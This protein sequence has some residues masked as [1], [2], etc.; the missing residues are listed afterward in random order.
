MHKYLWK[1]IALA[2]LTLFIIL[3]FSYTLIV[4]FI[5]NPFEIKLQDPSLSKELR[6]VYRIKAREYDATPVIVK[7]VNYFKGFFQGNFGDIMF[8]ANGTDARTIPELFFKPLKYSLL[9]SLPAFVISAVL[10]ITLGVFAGYKRGTLWDSIINIFVFVFIAIPSFI[11]APFFIDLFAKAGFRETFVAVG[12]ETGHGPATP[13]DSFVSV[14]PAILV[15]TL[16]S[17][18]VYTLY[19]RNQTVTVLTSNYIL[20]A[21]TKGL[22]G[23][24]IFFKYVFRNISIPLIAIVLPSYIGLLSGSIIL[25]RFWSIP[26]SSSVIASAFPNGEINIVMF[27]IFF[28][29]ALS[30]FTEILVD[31]SFVILDP[32][33]VYESSSGFDLVK[34]L[35]AKRIRSKKMRALFKEQALE[36]RKASPSVS[37]M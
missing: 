23:T 27:N 31:I 20:I 36:E 11:I 2:V 15:I 12:S 17:L 9:V 25:E 35:K 21:K 16:G 28:F 37:A 6:E 33:I 24:Q 3:I 7:L 8:P 32:R 10:G 30:L 18:A 14:I 29:T 26:G 1:R 22:S 5:T 4:S 13:W 19:A 34:Y